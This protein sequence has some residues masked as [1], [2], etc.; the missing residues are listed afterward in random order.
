MEEQPAEGIYKNWDHGGEVFYTVVCSC[1]S[2][3]DELEFSVEADDLSISVTTY[4]KPKSAYWKNLVGQTSHFENSFLWSLDYSIREL[5]NGLYHRL[6]VTYN[7]WVHGYV[8]YYSNTIMTEQQAL[9]YAATIK[10]AVADKR[11]FALERDIAAFESKLAANKNKN[12]EWKDQ[13]GDNV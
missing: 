10:A 9:N 1:G 7:V 3:D 12:T 5:I 4:L 8:Q 6:K 2:P 11:R 13:E